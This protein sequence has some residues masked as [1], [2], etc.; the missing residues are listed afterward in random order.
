MFFTYEF[1]HDVRF[2]GRLFSSKKL[3]RRRSIDETIIV[4]D[5]HSFKAL[6]DI[7]RG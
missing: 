2:I 7:A 6:G 4:R 3:W 5:N 1:G